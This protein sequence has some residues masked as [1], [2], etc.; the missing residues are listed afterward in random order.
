M[1]AAGY[2]RLDV[3]EL[4]NWLAGKGSTQMRRGAPAA[5]QFPWPLFFLLELT[6]AIVAAGCDGFR[7]NRNSASF[8]EPSERRRP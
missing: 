8:R 4:L 1:A 2:Q 7:H 6:L 5:P 3:P